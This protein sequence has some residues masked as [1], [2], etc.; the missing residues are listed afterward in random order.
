MRTGRGIPLALVIFGDGG[1]KCYEWEDR[2]LFEADMTHDLL[3][4]YAATDLS[5]LP[6]L[7]EWYISNRMNTATFEL[8]GYP[9]DSD[10][11]GEIRGFLKAL[12]PFYEHAYKDVLTNAIGDYLDDLLAHSRYIERHS[13]DRDEE[14]WRAWYFERFDALIKPFSLSSDV[15]N[16]FYFD[17]RLINVGHPK[18]ET[19]FFQMVPPPVGFSSVLKTQAEIKRRLLWILDI[20]AP[21]VGGLTMQQ[22]K[23]FYENMSEG[24]KIETVL[25]VSQQL[26]LKPVTYKIG[27][28]LFP[29]AEHAA[30]PGDVFKPL[31]PLCYR[32]VDTEALTSEMLDA[33]NRAADYT[34]TVSLFKV[35]GEYDIRSLYEL[36]YMEIYSMMQAKTI[37]RKC[38]HCNRYFIPPNRKVAYCDRTA[39][40]ESES[41]SVA[42]PKKAFQKKMGAEPALEMY[43]RA[44]KTHHARYTKGRMERTD[45]NGWVVVA[46]EKLQAV[47]N[48]TLDLSTFEAWL[49]E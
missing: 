10:G 33:L 15:V 13:D 16:K 1:Y 27:N 7:F 34:K 49:K 42:G 14:E 20:T 41:C 12:H 38:N 35:H 43:N 30:G 6:A 5:Q 11:H 40:G 45:F 18:H 44:Y 19:P 21:G 17:Y 4:N 32:D 23:W 8:N 3:F 39:E 48:G 46:K 24:L 9:R 25:K 37:I 2:F 47:R 29:G 22:R 36:L 28:A 26:P 31:Y